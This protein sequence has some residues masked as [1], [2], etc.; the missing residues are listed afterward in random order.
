MRE[1]YPSMGP[2]A[3]RRSMQFPACFPSALPVGGL[4]LRRVLDVHAHEANVVVLERAVLPFALMSGR[5]AS[6]TLGLEDAVDRI[7]VEMRQ[8]VRDH[9]GEVIKRKA[10]GLPQG[11]DENGLSYVSSGK[12]GMRTLSAVR[13]HNPRRR[14]AGVRFFPMKTRTLR[15]ARILPY[16]S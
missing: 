13:P 9:E 11:A 14:A 7:A 3:P 5:Q 10:A 8:K 2:F 16:G 12:T 4:Q 6:Q 15:M 1:V